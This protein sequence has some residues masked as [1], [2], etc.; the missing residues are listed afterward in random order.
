MRATLLAA[1][2][3]A[4]AVVATAATAV[5]ARQVG[6]DFQAKGTHGTANTRGHRHH[7]HRHHRRR[8][9]R[10]HHHRRHHRLRQHHR[11]HHR[12]RRARPHEAQITHASN[13]PRNA[14][15]ASLECSGANLIPT[16]A[17]LESVRTATFCLINRERALH[18]E[19]PLR[20][21]LKLQ[22]AAQ[23]HSEEM[24]AEDYFSHYE[25]SGEGP[26]GRM[27]ATGYI[28]PNV[29]YEV[30]ENIAW[31]TLRL[32]T[33]NAIVEGWMHSPGH[34]A[35]ILDASFRE[36]AI[37]VVAAVPRSF[38]KGQQ[39]AIYTQDFGVIITG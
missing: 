16:P 31:G 33:P 25:P 6:A 27:R 34:R 21:N 35:N 38:G 18:G 30:G 8:H 17:N 9:H 11:L 19:R 32:A 5:S 24:V 37:G 15:G 13:A 1:I 29:G 36:T 10:N 22:R 14:A 3:A 28:G 12:H 4:L 20:L 26:A 7:R 2:A 23:R 39:G